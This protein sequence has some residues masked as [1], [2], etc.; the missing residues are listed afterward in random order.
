MIVTATGIADAVPVVPARQAAFG[1]AFAMFRN[2]KSIAGLI[3]L[4]CL[5]AR[6]DL[7]P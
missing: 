3:I 7:R 4:G 5:R 1:E 2:R 6:R